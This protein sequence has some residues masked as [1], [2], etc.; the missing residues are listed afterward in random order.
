MTETVNLKASD[1]HELDVYVSHPKETPIG[2]LVVVQEAFGVNH[3]IRSVADGYAADAFLAVAP[4]L[5]DRIERKVELGYI[6]EDRERGIALAR[7]LN[8][9]DAVKDVAA[10]LLYLREKVSGKSGVIGYCLGGTI[11]WLAATRLEPAAAVGY[12]GGGLSRFAHENPGCPVMLHFGALDEHIPKEGIDQLQ[13]AHPDVQ[14]FWY[15]NADHGFNCDL[16]EA[17]N[18]EA[19]KLARERSLAFLMK[20]LRS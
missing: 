16:R 18:P 10:A 11:A 15:E 9:D 2:G 13:A 8:L 7:Q 4:A 17:Y 1:G 5:F 6:G 3:H 19:A 14:V 20:N 12:Y